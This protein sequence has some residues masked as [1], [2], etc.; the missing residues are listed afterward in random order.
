MAGQPMDR[1]T[2]RKVVGERHYRAKLTA[3]DVRMMRELWE[4]HG[5]STR[6]LAEKFEV[7]Q[8]A[9][10]AAVSRITWAHVR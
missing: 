3:D 10:F 2:R 4:R 1:D 8:R 7:S 5:V 6:S 9:A